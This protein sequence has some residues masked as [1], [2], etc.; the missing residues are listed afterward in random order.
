[1]GKPK[2][3]KQSIQPQTQPPLETEETTEA[4]AKSLAPQTFKRTL[5]IKGLYRAYGLVELENGRFQAIQ[6]KIFNGLVREETLMG[7]NEEEKQFA[8]DHMLKAISHEEGI[9]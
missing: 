5:P 1:M 6:V 8:Q 3:Q 2:T 9:R 4:T 7:P